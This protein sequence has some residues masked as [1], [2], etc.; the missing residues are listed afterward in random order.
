MLDQSITK[1][2]SQL[3][4][5]GFLPYLGLPIFIYKGKSV[6]A[7]YSH[8]PYVV[9]W[10]FHDDIISYTAFDIFGMTVNST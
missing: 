8:I 2:L 6:S 5:Y 3:Y 10:R 9:L 7:G 1:M 4:G